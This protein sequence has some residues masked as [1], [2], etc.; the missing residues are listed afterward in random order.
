MTTALAGHAQR[1]ATLEQA[2]ARKVERI[3]IEGGLDEAGLK[4]FYRLRALNEA[5]SMCTEA[6]D[7]FVC[8]EP[9]W[10]GGDSAGI[11]G[12]LVREAAK[13][14]ERMA[15]DERFK[16]KSAQE[17]IAMQREDIRLADK[18]KADAAALADARRR[19]KTAIMGR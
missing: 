19:G 9:P 14:A 3:K 7:A 15:Q 18:A 8:L 12:S 17:I 5:T 6:M 16:G 1:L 10:V 11:I 2:Q 13:D 4:E